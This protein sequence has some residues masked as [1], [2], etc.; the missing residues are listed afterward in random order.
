MDSDSFEVKA[1]FVVTHSRST[2]GFSPRY[3]VCGRSARRFSEIIM[4]SLALTKSGSVFLFPPQPYVN[5]YR[6]IL[7]P[8]SNL[9]YNSELQL[10][11]IIYVVL[12]K[13]KIPNP[14]LS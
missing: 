2:T 10:Q 6:C 5:H 9:I 7:G 1:G 13:V 4:P 12:Q 8:N 14:D 11:Y 3:T